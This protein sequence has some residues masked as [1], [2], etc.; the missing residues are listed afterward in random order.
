M[1]GF[2]ILW[3]PTSCVSPTMASD[4][5]ATDP[6]H[7]RL[8]PHLDR[9]LTE[10]EQQVALLVAEGLKDA[11]IGRQLGL[12]PATVRTYAGRIVQK[13]GLA[14]RSDLI[15]WMNARRDPTDLS[16]GLRRG[17]DG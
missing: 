5:R 6:T 2:D 9:R 12:S 8:G 14:R 4:R 17:E 3:R 7:P 15:A 13:L 1:D 16:S 10:R 11:S